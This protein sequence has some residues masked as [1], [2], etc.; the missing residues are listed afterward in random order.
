MKGCPDCEKRRK[1]MKE[2]Y[3]RNRHKRK[4]MALAYYYEHVKPNRE[5]LKRGAGIV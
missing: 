1:Q 3:A 5:K 4:H 2:Y